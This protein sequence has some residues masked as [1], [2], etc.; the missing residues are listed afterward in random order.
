[1]AIGTAGGAVIFAG[2]TV[3]IAVCGLGLIGIKFLGVMGYMSAISVLFA[4]ISALTLVPALISIFHKAIRPKV[5]RKSRKT[6]D[7]RW[8]RFVVG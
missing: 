5:E 6:A 8:S 4:V 2:I 3:I 1:L 7:T